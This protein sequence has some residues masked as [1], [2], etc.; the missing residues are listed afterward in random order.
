MAGAPSPFSPNPDPAAALY[1]GDSGRAYHEGKRGL[2]EAALPWV[3]RLRARKFQPWV[4]PESTVVELGVGAGWNLA[5]LKCARRV[6]CD[7]ADNP[8]LQER[9]RTLGIAFAPD[10]SGVTE[11]SADVAICHHTLEHL[12]E[13]AAALRGLQRILRP[14]GRLVLHV[15]WERERRYAR[16]DPSEPNHHLHGWNAQTLGNFATVLGWRIEHL[17]VRRYGYDRFAANLAH[18]LRVG[19]PGFRLLR[20][21]LITLSPLREVELIA[22]PPG[23][24]AEPGARAGH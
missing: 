24:S 18:R 8:G 17:T 1:R 19:E 10:L 16:F 23:T 2:P 22:A 7:A 4:K 21:T 11:A 3:Y 14:D 15:P 12:L 6:G 9:L 13:P 20:T 5:G